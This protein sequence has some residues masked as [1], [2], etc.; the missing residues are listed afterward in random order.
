MP[1][2]KSYTCTLKFLHWFMGF[3]IIGLFVAGFVMTSMAP[4]DLKWTTYGLHKSLGFVMLILVFVRILSRMMRPPKIK[5]HSISPLHYF[6][7]KV[8]V[9]V[10]YLIMLCMALSGFI[11]SD[12]G[13]YAINLF[14][15]YELPLLLT[16]TKFLAEYAHTIH[17]YAAP[18]G[19]TIIGLHI[20]AALYHHFILKDDT[21]KR[22]MPGQ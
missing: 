20:L 1:S 22:M 19:A 4:S 8:S 2:V 10:L 5:D 6:L 12:A 17:V 18:V 11:M 16:N 7:I 9:P 15:L 13:G 14:S 21:L 3:I